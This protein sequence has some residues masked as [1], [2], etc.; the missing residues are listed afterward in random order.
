MLVLIYA[1]GYLK[2]KPNNTASKLTT[3][4]IKPL[5]YTTIPLIITSY[6]EVTSPGSVTI[7]AQASGI[8][9]SVEFSPGQQVKKGQ[10][11]FTL[12]SNSISEQL[13]QSKA[14]LASAKEK[15]ESYINILKQ[16]KGSV[17]QVRLMEAKSAYKAA[18]AQYDE[19]KTIHNIISPIN[20]TISDTNLTVGAFVNNGEKLVYIASQ[21]NLQLRYQLPAQYAAQVALGQ[22]V[23]FYPRNT[24]NS[25][26]AKVSYISPAL[27]PTDYNITLRANLSNTSLQAN[28]FGHATQVIDPN[29]KLLAVSQ[30]LIRTD[31]SGFYVYV[32]ND[33]NT[34]EKQYCK[35]GGLTTSG[36]ITINSGLQ[37]GTKLII[38]NP[39]HFKTGEIVK[40]LTQ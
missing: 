26:T 40:A 16:V 14:T 30:S 32:L 12:R 6:A 39:N 10:L 31:S 3:V 24:K 1:I 5:T 33:K 35:L 11:L 17:S 36:L 34:V 37:T 2:N 13:S 8:I 29:R 9:T 25:Y 23:S 15:Y 20:G 38:S 4:V 19:T 18:L 7:N 22:K 27:N 21:G 28:T